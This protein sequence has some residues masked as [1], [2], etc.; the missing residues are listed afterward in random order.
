MKFLKKNL[1][2]K[3]LRKKKEFKKRGKKVVVIN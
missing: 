1:Y 2:K 3:K